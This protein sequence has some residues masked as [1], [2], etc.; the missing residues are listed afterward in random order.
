MKQLEQS[1]FVTAEKRGRWVFYELVPSTF[2]A[3]R[4]ALEK[5]EAVAEERV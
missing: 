3:V 1:G 2:R 4:D 5:F